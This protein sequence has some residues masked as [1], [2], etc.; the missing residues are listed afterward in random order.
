MARA[1]VELSKLDILFK[2]V[3]EF[4][5][6]PSPIRRQIYMSGQMRKLIIN[7]VQFKVNTLAAAA[8]IRRLFVVRTMR[9]TCRRNVV[10]ISG[11]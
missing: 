10:C 5:P 8:F 6:V 3:N 4:H 7:S 2:M 11:I 1:R 9:E